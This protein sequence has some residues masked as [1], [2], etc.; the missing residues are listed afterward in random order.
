M[1]DRLARENAEMRALLRELLDV[2][3]T[4]HLHD[5]V[6]ALLAANTEATS[7]SEQQGESKT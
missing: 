3:E 5:R 1:N 2:G 7:T 6:S 4:L